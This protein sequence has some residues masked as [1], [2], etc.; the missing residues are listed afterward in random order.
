MTVDY[1]ICQCYCEFQDTIE[2][3]RHWLSDAPLDRRHGNHCVERC[4]GITNKTIN[5][6]H[7]INI[8]NI[9]NISKS[10]HTPRTELFQL[11]VVGVL[12]IIFGD[13]TKGTII[14]GDATK[15]TIAIAYFPSI[16]TASDSLGLEG[17]IYGLL[18]DQ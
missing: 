2:K 3:D 10:S 18:L 17:L 9:S 7:I 14:F 11:V 15:G 4:H 12:Q 1:V 8:I 5:I 13:A 6:V 16:S